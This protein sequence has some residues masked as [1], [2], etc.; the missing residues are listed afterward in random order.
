MAKVRRNEFMGSTVI[1]WLLCITIIGIPVAVLYLIN[2]T[3]TVEED[4]D[5]SEE[6]ILAFKRGGAKKHWHHKESGHQ[7]K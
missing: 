5:D 4:I 2:G 7:R 1:F 6:F 3:L